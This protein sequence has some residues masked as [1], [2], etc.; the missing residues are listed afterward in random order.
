M[1]YEQLRTNLICLRKRKGLTQHEVG[2]LLGKSKRL[3]EKWEYGKNVPS[4]IDLEKLSHL[5]G[6]TIDDLVRHDLTQLNTY[7]KEWLSQQEA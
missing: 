2:E 7:N 6:T 4:T 1:S 5:Y 3:P